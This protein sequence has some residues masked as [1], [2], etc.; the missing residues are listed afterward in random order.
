MDLLTTTDLR[1]YVDHGL[2]CADCGAETDGFCCCPE[3]G[4]IICMGCDESISAVGMCLRCQ[5]DAEQRQ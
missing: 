4:A 5:L 2:F 3:C 1:T